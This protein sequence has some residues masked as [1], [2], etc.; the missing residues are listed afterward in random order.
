MSFYNK[1]GNKTKDKM[2]LKS[3]IT[4]LVPRV[5]ASIACELWDMGWDADQIRDLFSGSQER[6]QDSV[7]NNW[8][9]LQNVQDVTGIEVKYFEETGNIV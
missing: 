2:L 9:M 7:N 4:Y 1:R 8:D 6:W 3:Y 5:Y